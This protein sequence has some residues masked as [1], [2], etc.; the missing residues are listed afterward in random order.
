MELDRVKILVDKYLEAETTL[1][2]ERELAEYFATTAD[3]PQEF[4]PIKAMFAAMG[5]IK[6]HKAA[7]VARPDRQRRRYWHLIGG[8]G[9][10]VAVA[11]LILM[12]IPPKSATYDEIATP[13]WVVE[14]STP[15]A[16]PEFVC[17]IDG[18]QVT[19]KETAYAEVN[20]ILGG[21]SNNMQLAMAEVNK[22][23]ISRNR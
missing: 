5:A 14:L 11:C 13:Q 1:D 2:E 4:E 12:L 15:E 23:N 21:V 8:I 17:H 9:S 7:E 20:K 10:A 18:V 19:D 16:T 6:E 22:F 3:I